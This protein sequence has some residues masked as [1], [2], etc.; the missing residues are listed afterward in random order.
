MSSEER[1]RAQRSCYEFGFRV[2]CVYG[3]MWSREGGNFES[4]EAIGNGKARGRRNCGVGKV[5][6][7]VKKSGGIGGGRTANADA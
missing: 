2:V 3:E 6:R 5:E 1:R 4:Y 7:V